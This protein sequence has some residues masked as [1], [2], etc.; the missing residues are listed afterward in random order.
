MIILFIDLV[1]TSSNEY[2][3]STVCRLGISITY[4]IIQYQTKKN[5]ITRIIE[6]IS[7]RSDGC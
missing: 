7:I 3:R 1:S 5:N 4:P 6:T 2:G